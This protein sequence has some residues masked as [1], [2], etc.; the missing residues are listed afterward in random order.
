V[1]RVTGI[2]KNYGFRVAQNVINN[3]NIY[4]HSKNNL[5]NDSF[6]F[7]SNKI[8]TLYSNLSSAQAENII[9][10]IKQKDYTLLGEGTN[11]KCVKID[12]VAVKFL[13]PDSKNYGNDETYE[14]EALALKYIKNSG[15][16]DFQEFKD[17]IKDENDY[18]LITNI[19]EGKKINSKDNVLTS[20]KSADI[21][22]KLTLLDKSGFVQY[23]AQIENIFFD[24]DK[25]K[26]FDF[27]GFS[28][29]LSDYQTLNNLKDSGLILEYNFYPSFSNNK[30]S[31][32]KELDLETKLQNSKPYLGFLFKDSSA[33]SRNANPYFGALS[34]VANFEYR[35]LFF[36]LNDVLQKKDKQS[37]IDILNSY[38]HNK[39]E[40]FHKPMA[41]FF[42]NLDKKEVSKSCDTDILK[43]EFLIKKVVQHEKMM[44][45][46][47]SDKLSEEVLKTELAKIQ[48]RW[49]EF[50][51]KEAV[52][53]QYEELT[54]MIKNFKQN[55]TNNLKEYFGDALL[56][57]EKLKPE[58]FNIKEGEK[59]FSLDDSKNLTK[60]LFITSTKNNSELKNKTKQTFLNNNIFK[61]NKP[62]IAAGG[63]V[64][65]GGAI[66][67]Y[68][69]N[70]RKSKPE[71]NLDTQKE[72]KK[73]YSMQ[74]FMDLTRKTA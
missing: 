5:R 25:A 64:F 73:T 15:V 47:L 23:D 72:N 35:S 68:I 61:S 62:L 28:C 37:A 59:R 51:A 36:H 6:S 58:I 42:E 54:S 65:V 32:I 18:F 21:L 9:Q 45:N 31:K 12:E 60:N 48:M 26:M 11:S 55:A 22:K 46:I 41:D 50:E 39:A 66:A 57:F 20:Q 14:K 8:Q 53:T 16:E 71:E 19:I 3:P 10:K 4:Y 43:T 24:G 56:F 7:K 69:L 63:I 74:K 29:A 1:L 2:S 17:I 34:N 44:N 52:Q 13:K 70:K 38:L 40:F 30:I 33:L 49:V 27:G 67:A